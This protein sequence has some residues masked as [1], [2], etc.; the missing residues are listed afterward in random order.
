MALAQQVEMFPTLP[1]NTVL[2][3]VRDGY[4]Q[5]MRDQERL[6]GLLLPGMARIALGVSKARIHQLMTDGVLRFV[7]HDGYKYVS[8]ADVTQRLKDKRDGRIVS[9]RPVTK[10]S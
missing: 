1:R 7:T 10:K 5:F 4:N 8:A 9:H 2:Q 6:G 3:D